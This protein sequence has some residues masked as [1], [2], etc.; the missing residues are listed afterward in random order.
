MKTMTTDK[1]RINKF[2]KLLPEQRVDDFLNFHLFNARYTQKDLDFTNDYLYECDK[3]FFQFSSDNLSKLKKVFDNSFKKLTSFIASNF[4]RIQAGI[5]VLYPDFKNSLD[6]EKQNAWHKKLNEVNKLADITEKD[7]KNLLKEMKKY[8]EEAEQKKS[9]ATI[10]IKNSNGNVSV[11]SPNSQQS[12]NISKNDLTPEVLEILKQLQKA[13][14]EKDEKKIDTLF[15]KLKAR[16]K[17]IFWGVI[18]NGLSAV[19]KINETSN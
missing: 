14:D 9:A 11:N 18:T 15:K 6:T 10:N 8:L 2:I 13:V 1:S 17:N 7:Y 3:I 19:F 16:A 4:F 12:V 5:Y